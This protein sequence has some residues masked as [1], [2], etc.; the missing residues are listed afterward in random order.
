M[1]TTE[2]RAA[3]ESVA[4]EVDT[5]GF[6][7]PPPGEWDAGRIVAHLALND[8]LLASVTE[9][10]LA[11]LAVGF[12]NRA[13]L[14][15][16]PATV[17]VLRRSGARLCDLVDRLTE[18]QAATVLPVLIQDGDEIAVDRPMPWGVLLGL[19]A[20]FHLPAHGDQLRALRP[21]TP[22]G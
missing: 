18:E 15:P 4:A 7:P 5:G 2:L 8:D 12:D 9:A 3:Y 17:D 21:V 1:D 11:G 14:R 22:S 10:V 16:E 20:S 13:S 19:Q 6:G